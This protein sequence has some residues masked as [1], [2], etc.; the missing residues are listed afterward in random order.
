MW[1][2]TAQ[3]RSKDIKLAVPVYDILGALLG[4]LTRLRHSDPLLGGQRLR[5]VQQLLE[6]RQ[7]EHF[8]YAVRLVG[9]QERPNPL[10][11]F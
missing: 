2:S 3:F 6:L 8:T 1:P 9:S 4:S 11:H 10:G 5:P 7:P